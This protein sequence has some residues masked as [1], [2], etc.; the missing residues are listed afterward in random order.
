MLK[1]KIIKP[2]K[3][4]E[5]NKNHEVFLNLI[6]VFKEDQH[7]INDICVSNLHIIGILNSFN[8]I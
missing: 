2:T 7:K 8:G 4:L 3:F 5:K 1:K 6:S